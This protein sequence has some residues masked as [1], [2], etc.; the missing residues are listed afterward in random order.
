MLLPSFTH[1]S[2]DFV[3]IAIP[4]V[5]FSPLV[6]PP[7]LLFLLPQAVKDKASTNVNSSN[8][9]FFIIAYP[10]YKLISD[11]ESAY[12]WKYTNGSCFRIYNKT[13]LFIKIKLICG[14]ETTGESGSPSPVWLE[15]GSCSA[16]NLQPGHLN[17]FVFT[18]SLFSAHF[19]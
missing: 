14:E 1:R 11:Y 17:S 9:A 7:A 16:K 15:I 6:E 18:T 19:I 3:G 5:P 2:D 8:V 4:T 10:L 12:I 13:T